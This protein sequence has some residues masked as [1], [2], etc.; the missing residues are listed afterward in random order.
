MRKAPTALKVSFRNGVE[1][2]ACGQGRRAEGPL[3]GS[4]PTSAVGACTTKSGRKRNGCFR[5]ST[6]GSRRQRSVGLVGRCWCAV[7]DA[8]WLDLMLPA[9]PAPSPPSLAGL[10]PFLT[11]KEPVKK[12]FLESRGRVNPLQTKRFC[13]MRGSLAHN[14]DFRTTAQNP[15]ILSGPE[16]FPWH[17]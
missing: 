12:A 3:P 5:H 7:L 2:S 8:E 9:F 1:H 6:N 14:L 13:P 17:S 15:N 4:K 10:C 11:F 16:G